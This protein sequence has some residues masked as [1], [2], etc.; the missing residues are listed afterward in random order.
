MADAL[1]AIVGFGTGI[2]NNQ[3]SQYNAKKDFERQK[4]LMRLSHQYSLQDF[5]IQNSYNSPKAQMQRLKDAG[6]NPDMVYGSGSIGTSDA[7]VPQRGTP[8]SSMAETIPFSNPVLDAVQAA[9]GMAMAKK[10]KS[11]TLEQDIRNRYVER[12]VIS[13]LRLQG[14]EIAKNDKSVALM[15]QQIQESQAEI[16]ALQKRVDNESFDR[17]LSAFST[18][19]QLERWKHQNDLDDEQKSWLGTHAMAALIGARG[20]AAQANAIAKAF[21]LFRN[22]KVLRSVIDQYIEEGKKV[23]DDLT[24]PAKEAGDW[25]LERLR[26]LGR[27]ID[28]SDPLF[29]LGKSKQSGGVR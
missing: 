9:Q 23:V 8:G 10:T 25:F 12:E 29:G 24:E 26:A 14:S 17:A 16:D 5:A 4:E 19:G 11:E 20:A 7:S 21:E 3:V 2:M 1:S 6:L 15:T 13:S 22:P 28:S 27:W 18:V